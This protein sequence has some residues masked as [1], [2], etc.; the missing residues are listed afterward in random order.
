[1]RIVTS[2][3][4][5]FKRSPSEPNSVV[6]IVLLFSEPEIYLEWELEAA[7]ERAWGVP[8]PS[9]R[10]FAKTHGPIA[11]VTIGSQTV[12]I[13]SVTRPYFEPKIARK[14]QPTWAEHNAFVTVDHMDPKGNQSL[15]YATIDKLV[16]ELLNENCV[17]TDSPVLGGFVRNDSSLRDQLS[18]VAAVIDSTG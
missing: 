17:G 18:K 13:T 8:F 5:K 14:I 3:F 11:F 15:R 9:E 16:Q 4:S 10:H 2:L 12:M 7:A 6:S 1:M